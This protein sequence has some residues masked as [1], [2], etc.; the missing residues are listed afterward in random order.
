MS[1][2]VLRL[3]GLRDLSLRQSRVLG[4]TNFS[5][6]SHALSRSVSLRYVEHL[7][8]ALQDLHRPRRD[9]LIALDSMPLTMAK[10]LRH[11][12]VKVNRN[13]VGGG[14]LWSYALNAARGSCPVKIHKVIAGAW[15]DAPLMADVNLV[16]AGPV[17]L[18]DRGFLDYALIERWLGEGLRFVLRMRGNTVYEVLRPLSVPRRYGSGAIELDALVRLGSKL[19]PAHPVVRLIV[20]RI[21]TRA[22]IIPLLVTTSETDWSAERVLEA[23]RKRG[24]IEKFHQF[25]KS[26]VGLAHLYSF[27]QTGI[28]FLLYTALLLAIVLFLSAPSA[29]GDVLRTL[30]TQLATLRRRVGL[31]HAWQRNMNNRKRDKAFRKWKRRREEGRQNL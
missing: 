7:V 21:S 17:Y 24:A 1:A 8:Q 14:V 3:S 5:S 11:R 15:M 23:Y 28:T 20:A 13:T 9:E 18:M 22:G 10:S 2:F 27:S 31:G 25:L 19:T 6:L 16:P 26:T 30:M 4:S 12:C 29:T